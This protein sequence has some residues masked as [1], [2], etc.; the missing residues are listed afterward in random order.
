MAEL[1]Q[2][3]PFL[4]VC[5][6]GLLLVCVADPSYPLPECSFSIT[7]DESSPVDGCAPSPSH[8]SP[9]LTCNKLRDAL[10]SAS[11]SFSGDSVCISMGPGVHYVDYTT[12]EI[13]CNVH[14]MGPSDGGEARVECDPNAAFNSSI[15]GQ[16]PLIFGNDT[17]VVLERVTF[18]HCG[19]SLLFNSTAEVKAYNCHFR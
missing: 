14:I 3:K 11:A 17:S 15:Y 6:C 9:N 4:C 7:V 1:L 10:T 5:L 18:A 2:N 16:F 19:R 12:T 13:K 8:L